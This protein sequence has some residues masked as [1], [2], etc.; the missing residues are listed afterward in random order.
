MIRPNVPR[1]RATQLTGQHSA[2]RTI[3]NDSVWLIDSRFV[4]GRSRYLK[5]IVPM[6]DFQHRIDAAFFYLIPVTF[7]ATLK[8]IRYAA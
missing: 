1:W 2:S 8:V 6:K 4:T 3:E 7:F 5:P